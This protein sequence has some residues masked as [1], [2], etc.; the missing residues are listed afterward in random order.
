MK[1]LSR[2]ELAAIK[3][4]AQNVKSMLKK[5][6]KLEE[7]QAEI[8][9]EL[10]DIN[11]MIDMWEEPIKKMTGGFT[12]EQVLNGE[13]EESQELL[14]EETPSEEE[15]DETPNEEIEALPTEENTGVSAWNNPM[16]NN[17]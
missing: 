10:N 9:Q 6:D 16:F 3:R 1:E 4:T 13:M 14:S 12:S 7:K 8:T 15:I 17:N 5:R 11:N 2:F